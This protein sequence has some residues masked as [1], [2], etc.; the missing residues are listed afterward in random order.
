MF[1]KKLLSI[2]VF[3]LFSLLSSAQDSARQTDACR[4]RISILTC[5]PGEELYSTFGHTA[6]RIIDSATNND[7]VFNYGTF[8]FSDPNFYSKFVKGKLEYFLSFQPLPDFLYGYQLEKRSVIE[9]ELALTC[10]ERE[11]FYHAI[12]NNLQGANKF[13][14][15]DFL[16]DN[17]TSRVRDL[18]EKYTSHFHLQQPIIQ[19]GTTSRNLL[20]EYLDL[21]GKP[22]SK[23]GIDILLGSKLDDTI[24]NRQAM[25][26]PDYLMKGIDVATNGGTEKLVKSK[27]LVLDAQE[28]GD[29]TGKNVP[30]V[31]FTFFAV[32]VIIVSLLSR[33]QNSLFLKIVDSFLFY[34]AGIMGLLLLFMWFGTDHVVCQDNFNLLWAIP[35]HFI[36]AF[37]IVRKR[38]W[39]RWYFFLSAIIHALTL[40]AWFWLPQELNLALAPFVILLMFRSFQLTKPT[41]V[42][43]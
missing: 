42:V 38:R 41:H 28:K 40:V 18:L 20:H 39:M 26:L 21:G 14:K 30:L 23:L 1:L 19:N 10:Q 34:S 6:I 25:F 2:F 5:A 32:I 8:D 27:Q 7:L 16:Y 43:I 17:C 3:V 11:A 36:A 12:Q 22:W 31:V 13:Y 15:Y 29:P 33:F 35:T 4:L 9:Q 24:S 37:F